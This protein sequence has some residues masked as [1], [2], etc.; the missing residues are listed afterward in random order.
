MWLFN[1]GTSAA[2]LCP[3]PGLLIVRFRTGRE[4]PPNLPPEG[5]IVGKNVFRGQETF[6]RMAD[7]DRRRH[8]YVIGQTGTGKTSLMKE[9]IRQDIENGRGVCV[10]DPHGEFAEYALSI[11]PQQRAEDVIYF[12]PADIERPLGLNMLEIK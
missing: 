11:I 9:M 7:N 8:L 12:D 3:L 10:I 1:S 6:V 4:P 2:L 5:I